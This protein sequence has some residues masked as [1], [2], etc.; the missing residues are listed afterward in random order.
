MYSWYQG[1]EEVEVKKNGT[2]DPKIRS[3]VVMDW[4]AI[5]YFS[6]WLALFLAGDVSSGVEEE[7]K[8]KKKL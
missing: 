3:Y 7:S 8:E 5:D 6:H 1:G 4:K 2:I